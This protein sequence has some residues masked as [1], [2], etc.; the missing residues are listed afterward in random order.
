MKKLFIKGLATAV[1]GLAA[2]PM[3]AEFY[4]T[5]E[6]MMYNLDPE[7]KTA[8]LYQLSSAFQ[9]TELVVP[10]TVSKDGVD[11]TITSV[12]AGGCRN[13]SALTSVTLGE[14]I[15]VVGENAFYGCTGVTELNLPS[16]LRII[17]QMA[18]YGMTSL[19]SVA[20]PEGIDSIG[21]FAFYNSSSIST[22]T[23]PASV[24]KM[25]GNPWGGCT[26]LTAISVAE[27]SKSFAAVGGVL[28]DID[29]TRLIAAPCLSVT[30]MN[31][32]VPSTVKVI[33]NN[34]MRNNTLLRNITFPEGLEK[35]ESGAFYRDSQLSAVVLP[36]TVSFIGAD[37]FTG[38]SRISKYEVAEANEN[39]TAI[40]NC[41]YTKDVTKL[42]AVAN[43]V[44]DFVA[45]D[46]L[47][48]IDDGAFYQSGVTSVSLNKV[49]SIGESSFE[50]CKSLTTVDFGTALENIGLR[51]F[52]ECVI[53]N[54]K[55]PA[56]VRT[57]GSQAFLN[58]RKMETL[59]LNDGLTTIGATAFGACEALTAVTIPGSVKVTGN[60]SFYQCLELS[61]VTI[62]EGVEEISGYTFGYCSSLGD[63]VL[64]ST[65]KTI[66]TYAFGYS[67]LT[68]IELS[69][70]L[71]DIGVSAF[72]DTFLS[73][74][75]LPDAVEKVGIFAF[76]YNNYLKSFKAGKGLRKLD[77]NAIYMCPELE[78]VE[79]NEGLESIGVTAIAFCENLK[80][81]EI[82]STV[83]SIGMNAFNYDK[84]LETIVNKATVPQ[85]L[86]FDLFV[87]SDFNGYETVKLIVP[88]ESVDAYKEA[89]IW[90]K[91]ATIESNKLSGIDDVDM[92]EPT[93]VESYGINGAR[94][95][96]NARGYRIDRMSDGSVRKVYVK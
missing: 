22:V 32:T 65:V 19:S 86:S 89:N 50:G 55:L 15:E 45:P 6:G 29:I 58:N 38:C 93:V 49:K 66:G 90:K 46:A 85:A 91:F 43:T 79:L 48:T 33:G 72:Y 92:A 13:K 82:P 75:E 44:K 3:S 56:T 70:S 51:A 53:E 40:D 69:E 39:F 78:T 88:E 76:G 10:A 87:V 67:G 83:T 68:S 28:F 47:E 84:G 57:I 16:S 12:A 71:T 63:V 7:T 35:I 77:T 74:V 23:V 60:Q 52:Q 27:G 17:D 81:I 34:S 54:V 26:S 20:L 36:S 11:Y 9:G 1:L 59:E 80:T 5:P 24:T 31:Y 96:I 25:G 18:F 2:L 95:G 8:S 4:L 30:L 41:L 73:E 37:V 14:N 64:P 62:E 21:N 42:I 94:Q 61:D